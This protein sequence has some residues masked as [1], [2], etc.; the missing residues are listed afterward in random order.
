MCS[1]RGTWSAHD[2]LTDLWCTPEDYTVS[3]KTYRAHNG[4]LE[5]ARG[6]ASYAEEII[7]K[8]LED[9]PDYTLLLVGH[10]LGG[11]VAAILGTLWAEKFTNI[12]VFGFGAACVSPIDDTSRE[13]DETNNGLTIFTVLLDGDPFSCLSLGHVADVSFALDYLCQNPDLRSTVLMRTDGPTNQIE[14]R[15]L[16]WC[17]T[18]M[19]E[20]HKEVA[21]EKLFPPGRLIFMP[22][23]EKGHVQYMM[24]E[25]S[26]QFFRYWKI[27]RRMFDLSR[28]VPRLYEAKLKFWKTQMEER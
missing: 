22:Y 3:T 24:R 25:V 9:N 6:L 11:S 17:S 5:A 4:M 18:T 19:E 26:P 12:T 14:D 1:I 27:G 15:D 2:V 28:H 20:I 16:E 10:S 8:E 21:N 13:Q 23:K 7:T